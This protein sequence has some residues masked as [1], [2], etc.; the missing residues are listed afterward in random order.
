MIIHGSAE[1]QIVF[2]AAGQGCRR[3]VGVD[4]SETEDKVL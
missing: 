2:Q 3:P 4:V 1:E